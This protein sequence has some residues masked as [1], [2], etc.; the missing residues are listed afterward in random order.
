MRQRLMETFD[1][2]CTLDL[3]GEAMKKERASN[4]FK[5]ESVFS[6]QHGVGICLLVELLRRG[7]E[8]MFA[9]K[10][11]YDGRKIVLPAKRPNAAPG[12]VVVVFPE[13]RAPAEERKGWLKAQEETFAKVWDNEE[14]AVYDTL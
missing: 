6:T 4:G 1:E 12:E 7:G 3:Q 13:P 2:L 5:E 8:A 11:R 9:V 10:A 14:D